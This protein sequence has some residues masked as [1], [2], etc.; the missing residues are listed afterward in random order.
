MEKETLKLLIQVI[1]LCMAQGWLFLAVP[2][3]AIVVYATQKVYLRTSRRLRFQELELR[4]ALLSNI[5]ESV[6]NDAFKFAP[7]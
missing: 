2:V 1:M 6:S 4:G 5:V 7:V 3:G